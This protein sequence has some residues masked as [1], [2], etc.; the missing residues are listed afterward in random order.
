LKKLYII[1]NGFDLHHELDTKYTSFGLFLKKNFTDIYV[2]LIEYYGFSE[3]RY[4]YQPSPDDALWSDFE[5]SLALLDVD[6]VLEAHRDSIANPGSAD[7]RDRDW[8]TFAIDIETVVATLTV[9]LF[10]AFKDFILQVQYPN[11]IDTL[12]LLLDKDSIY[13]SFNYTDTLERFYQVKHENILYIHGKASLDT[14]DLILGHAQDPSNFNEEVEK[15]PENLSEEELEQWEEYMSDNYN[16]SFELG[17]HEIE[18][19]F[20]DTF[21]PTDQV[22]EENLPFFNQLNKV[23]EVFVLGHSLSNVDM[24]YFEKIKSN[25]GNKPSWT[26]TYFGD[27]QRNT[28][29]TT[30]INLGI[31]IENIRL[32][33]MDD[34]K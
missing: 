16:L 34:L 18:S 24:P 22:I 1:G 2:Q 28:H 15:P 12:K 11:S 8:G 17:K 32:I 10:S 3:L 7:F 5:N 20:A 26:A 13:L 23:E 4:P 14:D 25:I 27:G 33:S 6:T 21:K 30:L 31:K 9:N 29:K 19:Y